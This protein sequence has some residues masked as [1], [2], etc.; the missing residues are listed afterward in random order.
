MTESHGISRSLQVK[1]KYWD[2]NYIEH[3]HFGLPLTEE[4]K[5]Y[6]SI[7]KHILG[8]TRKLSMRKNTLLEIMKVFI[9]LPSHRIL[10]DSPQLLTC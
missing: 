1:I 10:M 3:I 9:N 5:I 8:Y 4:L 7:S 6:G 2:I